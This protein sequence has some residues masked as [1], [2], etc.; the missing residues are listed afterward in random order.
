[1]AKISGR[2]TTLHG[3]PQ[4][5]VVIAREYSDRKNIDALRKEAGTFHK[6]L[7]QLPPY[8]VTFVSLENREF[9]PYQENDIW[10]VPFY[11][12]KK[13]I[14]ETFNP[15]VIHVFEA[16]LNF[17]FGVELLGI[18]TFFHNA[19]VDPLEGL[20]RAQI[21]EVIHLCD[22]DML[23]LVVHSQIS[24]NYARSAGVKNVLR[25]FP[26]VSFDEFKMPLKQVKK[27]KNRFSHL[28]LHRCRLNSLK[29]NR[30]GFILY[31]N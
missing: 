13:T 5:I 24:Q 7:A 2:N 11:E 19:G 10:Y 16:G 25:T 14:I 27:G 3:A 28:V 23:F 26:I 31:K 18:K 15:D 4:R 22:H 6:L 30:E 21:E 17:L 20:T 9:E 29:Q 8:N 1:M 12:A